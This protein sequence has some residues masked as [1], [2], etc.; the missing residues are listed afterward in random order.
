MSEER[1][2]KP[3][4]EELGHEGVASP[5]ELSGS[6][7]VLG[8]TRPAERL[9]KDPW[10][11]PDDDEAFDEALLLESQMQAAPAT[12]RVADVGSL[13]S[14]LAESGGGLHEPRTR[15]TRV[16]HRRAAVT[17]KV[18][19]D[20]FEL[21]LELTRDASP[22][23]AGLGEPV[24]EHDLRSPALPGRMQPGWPVA[25]RLSVLEGHFG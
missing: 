21:G 25:G 18:H 24:N 23:G 9:V 7:I 2:L 10:V 4:I 19:N 13:S 12:E 5:F 16:G 3:V 20:E 14:R 6:L 15:R 1:A 11:R 22:G 8:H 17:G